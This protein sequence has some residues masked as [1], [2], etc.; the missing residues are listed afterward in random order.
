MNTSTPS[1]EPPS[2]TP[3]EVGRKR[4]P[5]GRLLQVSATLV[6]LGLLVKRID[7][8][9]L[10]EALAGV[11]IAPFVVGCLLSVASMGPFSL[12]QAA[13][14]EPT[15][16]PVGFLRLVE[17]NFISQFYGMFLPAWIGTST[18]RWYKITGNR[19]GRRKVAL[20]ILL[21]Q[22]LTT[23]GLA[24]LVLLPL[25]LSTDPRIATFRS[26]ALPILA[27][28]VLIGTAVILCWF[29]P[30]AFRIV[31][32][33]LGRVESHV[34]SKPVKAILGAYHDIGAFAGR[35]AVLLKAIVYQAIFFGFSFS[36]MSLFF[37][38]L[39]LDVGV[40]TMLWISML[41]TLLQSI[42]V[43]FAGFGVREAGY[44]F[45]LGLFGAS[46][47]QGALLGAMQ[48]SALVLTALTGAA[49]SIKERTA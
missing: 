25:A 31:R 41:V 20:T 21:E 3:E 11:R 34:R 18:V 14:L 36:G 39:G 33:L 10:R 12:R 24:L 32:T 46:A 35:P 8:G 44:S 48:S 9:A 1:S 47:V 17:I 2:P 43:S 45:L 42:P 19:V 28:I 38:A 16:I 5:L 23:T 27:T 30:A 49:L 29:L 7:W 40:A 4:F 22:V 15:G 37:G 26:T 13:L 6:L